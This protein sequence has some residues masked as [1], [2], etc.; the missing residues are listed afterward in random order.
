[1]PSGQHDVVPGAGQALGGGE[2]DAGAASADQSGSSA[3]DGLPDV[4]VPG[5]A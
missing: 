2:P 5:L 4:G 1:V 3:D